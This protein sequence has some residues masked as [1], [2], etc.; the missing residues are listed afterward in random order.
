MKSIEVDSNP[1][2]TMPM[3]A[4]NSIEKDSQW[5]KS[6][7]PNLWTFHGP[8]QTFS[9]SSSANGDSFAC[10][11]DFD[12]A[13]ALHLCGEATDVVLR[14]AGERQVAAIVVA[15]CCVGKLQQQHGRSSNNNNPYV[16]QATG[17]NAPT[18]QYP[19]SAAFAQCMQSTTTSTSTTTTTRQ[20]QLYDWDALAKAADY[21]DNEGEC[22]TARN[23]TRRTAKAL[24]ETDR[25]LFLQETYQYK[26]ALTRMQPW[27]ATPKND[28]LVAWKQ[29]HGDDYHNSWSAPVE[30]DGGDP[31][32]NQTDLECQADIQLT[33]DHLLGTKLCQAS[34][35]STATA[36]SASASSTTM[37]AVA[38]DKNKDDSVD[39]TRE[40]MEDIRQQLADFLARTGNKENEKLVFPTGMGGRRRK[41]VHYMAEQMNLAHW[42]EGS[43]NAEKTVAVRRRW[44]K[45]PHNDTRV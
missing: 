28:I 26:T 24:L 44:Q 19:Q 6:A 21:S 12:M 15:P 5:Q 10:S 1:P 4:P 22:R 20:Q 31:I 32:P 25:R 18:V 2:E 13:I 38:L 23:A 3:E 40:E 33:T 17:Q 27:E 34:L 11:I 36:E 7:I 41:L 42:C 35:E 45:Q 16:F 39:W 14:L 30:S 37:K 8:A 9:E 29:R 43:K